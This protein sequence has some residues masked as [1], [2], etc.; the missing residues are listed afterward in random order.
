MRTNSAAKPSSIM[1]PA[2]PRLI[3]LHSF[4]AFPL[5]ISAGFLCTPA[6]PHAGPAQLFGFSSIYF[7]RIFVH[8]R[9]MAP[10]HKPLHKNPVFPQYISRLAHSTH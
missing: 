6:P 3:A 9:P 10:L 2:E 8:P 5:Y 4:S 1:A 7:C